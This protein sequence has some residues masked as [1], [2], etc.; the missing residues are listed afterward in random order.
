MHQAGRG[1]SS[2][3]ARL[4]IVDGRVVLSAE[5]AAMSADERIQTLAKAI[6][7][8]PEGFWENHVEGGQRS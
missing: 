7:S 2:D 6:A 1:W 3:F 5:W 8:M 4:W